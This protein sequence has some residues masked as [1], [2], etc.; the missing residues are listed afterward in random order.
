MWCRSCHQNCKTL[1]ELWRD[2]CIVLNFSMFLLIFRWISLLLF[3]NIILLQ[4]IH[5]SC[6]CTS[7]SAF[8]AVRGEDFKF[9]TISCTVAHPILFC[10]RTRCAVPIASVENRLCPLNAA[11]EETVPVPCHLLCRMKETSTRTK[12]TEDL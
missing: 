7:L 2:T 9:A 11:Y 6:T 8:A 12:K 4:G 1:G 3:M 10:T 5:Y